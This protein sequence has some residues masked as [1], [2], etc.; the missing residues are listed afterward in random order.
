MKK[1][2]ILTVL[3]AS[4]FAASAQV[5][6]P[7]TKAKT[8]NSTFK[9]RTYKTPSTSNPSTSS[10]TYPNQNAEPKNVVY[11]YIDTA[12]PNSE[13]QFPMVGN[14]GIGTKTPQ[15][16]LE[17]KR[18]AGNTRRKNVLLQLSNSWSPNGQNEPSLMFSNGDLSDPKNVSYWT[19]GAR[20][21]G[22]N[23]I[24]SP[25]TFKI[26]YKAPG[27]DLDQEVFSIDSYH[28]KVKIGDVSTNYDGYKLFVEEGILTEKVKVAIKNSEDWFDNVFELDYKLMNIY[29][30]DGF[31]KK[32]K[33]LPD[34]PTTKDVT[35]NG[36]DLGK[37]N[38]LLLKKIEELTLY[39]ID[40]K[41]QLDDTKKMVE[42]LK[43]PHK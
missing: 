20:V 15:A 18:N 22:D 39:M 19:V 25:Q 38:G 26:C 30:L 17:I 2:A 33:H 7:T 35:T 12:F 29:D 9:Q 28:G 37:M 14:I 23:T 5:K 11:Q 32:Y 41:K 16:A 4:A 42:D 10:S 3:I 1:I 36:L 21:S 43:K 31:I 8:Y 13:N 27:I 34:I 6:K 24:K 40:L